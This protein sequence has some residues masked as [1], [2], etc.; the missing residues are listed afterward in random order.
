MDGYLALGFVAFLRLDCGMFFWKWDFF[1]IEVLGSR[2]SVCQPHA[3][4]ECSFACAD[5]GLT[6]EVP[7]G[8]YS[9]QAV[10]QRQSACR[11]PHVDIMSECHLET[12]SHC[13]LC[14]GLILSY[15]IEASVTTDKSATVLA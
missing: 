6:C 9:K 4:N 12:V 2:R 10:Q 1:G 11:H 13:M 15:L 8:M 14:V 3:R 5:D 7:T